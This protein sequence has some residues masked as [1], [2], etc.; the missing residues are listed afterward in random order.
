MK[1][2]K[3]ISIYL[4]LFS[5]LFSYGQN[6]IPER[7]NP[8]RLVNDLAGILSAQE[9]NTLENKLVAFN[10]STGTQIVVVTVNDLGDYDKAEFTYTLGQKWGVGQ[11]DFSNGV[12]IMVKPHGGQGQRHAFI[13]TGYGLEGVIPDA[14]AKRIV[15]NEMI[16]YFKENR[17]YEG[18]NSAVDI[19]MGLASQEF[20]ADAYVNKKRVKQ[21]IPAFAVIFII[22]LFFILLSVAKSK[23][24]TLGHKPN[25]WTL[26]W[27]MSQANRSHG[28]HFGN[29][30]GG[31]GSF[32][33]G[34]GGGF[35]GFGGGSF[36]G[37][38]AG[39]SW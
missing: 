35:G 9:V 3:N 6:G 27:L 18:I 31:R 4:L 8:P 26:L 30:T 11:K 12:V 17:F 15:E 14:V 20:T 13:A 16:P 10:D 28:G 37:G 19:V 38:G 21:G 24:Q 34:G 39:G 25:I 7:P 2:I 23:H 22:V 29:F 5:V 36:G 32:G 1:F 33:G